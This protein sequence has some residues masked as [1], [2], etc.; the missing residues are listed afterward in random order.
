MT[1]LISVVVP[2]RDHADALADCLD[3][4]ARQ[5][6]APASEILVVDNG[7]PADLRGLVARF[8]RARYARDDRPEGDGSGLQ[9]SGL[10][11]L[12]G[13]RSHENNGQAAT[14]AH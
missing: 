10:D 4:L 1:P 8:P 9:H 2:V 14:L 7:A 11:P 12:V 5:R 3:A 13:K 6:H